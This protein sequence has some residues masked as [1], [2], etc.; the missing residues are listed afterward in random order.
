VRD[1]EICEI[2]AMTSPTA[3]HSGNA[4]PSARRT[5]VVVTNNRANNNASRWR[6]C[7]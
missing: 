7:A 3:T 6:T 1:N 5:A 4:A 2:D